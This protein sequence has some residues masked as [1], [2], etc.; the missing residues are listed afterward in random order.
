[1]MLAAVC[2]LCQPAAVERLRVGGAGGLVGPVVVAWA[3]AVAA[4]RQHAW[5]VSERMP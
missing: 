4:Q 1:M 3:V 5:F 2:L